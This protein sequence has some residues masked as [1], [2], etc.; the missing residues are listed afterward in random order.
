MAKF[1]DAKNR[2]WEIPH[3]DPYIIAEVK[4][5]CGVSLYELPQKP[6]EFGNLC[7]NV[8]LFANVLWLLVKGQNG[9]TDEREFCRGLI[10]GDVLKNAAAAMWE[11]VIF[12]SPSEAH[13]LMRKMMEQAEAIQAEVRREAE[14]RLATMNLKNTFGK[15]SD[16]PALNRKERRSAG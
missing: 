7:Q 2:E 10:G 6:E 3:F 1:T 13:P 5:G 11:E 16:L 8:P 12:F 9:V 15:S 14:K 4:Q